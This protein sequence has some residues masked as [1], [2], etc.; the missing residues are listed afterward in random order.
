MN[1]CDATMRTKISLVNG[2]INKLPRD[3]RDSL[4]EQLSNLKQDTRGSKAALGKRLKQFY[5]ESM[6]RAQYISDGNSVREPWAILFDYYL[7]IDF[8]ATC[9]D[10]PSKSWPAEIIEFPA[11]LLDCRTGRTEGEFRTFC[12]PVMEPILT[13]FCTELTGIRQQDVENA[14]LFPE[15]L[16][17]FQ[18][19]L[20]SRGLGSEYSFAIVTDSPWDM[21]YYLRNQCRYC[22]IE[23]PHFAR[24][25]V[26]VRKVFAGF[27][28]TPRIP[29]RMMI[30]VIGRRFIGRS[31]CGID[32]ARNI[33]CVVRRLLQDGARLAPN[34]VL[35]QEAWWDRPSFRDVPWSEFYSTFLAGPD[36]AGQLQSNLN[37]Q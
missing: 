30:W 14:P 24:Y 8:E 25:W 12:R 18:Q 34:E 27:Y 32:D 7:I 33:A 11:V 9:N 36:C 37:A 35:V 31:H 13:E 15:V 21:A 3:G 23:F 28:S 20:Q 6:L 10:G 29:L 22:G 2:M 1:T 4:I 19:W 26:N 5:K 16:A 17:S